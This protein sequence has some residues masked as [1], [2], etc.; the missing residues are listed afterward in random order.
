M[1]GDPDAKTKSIKEIL[2]VVSGE[3]FIVNIEPEQFEQLKAQ[4]REAIGIAAAQTSVVAEQF[5]QLRVILSNL[6]RQ[7]PVR[8]GTDVQFD[9]QGMEFDIG[10]PYL[11]DPVAP[12]T[13]I[14][15]RNRR[16][17]RRG[18]RGDSEP[19]YPVP[20]RPWERRR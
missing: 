8:L 9:V 5:N 18:E 16:E 1:T 3:R 12:D 20:R 4:M 10:E 19:G 17:R 6:E 13:D 2:V 11:P 15:P 7:I 14:E